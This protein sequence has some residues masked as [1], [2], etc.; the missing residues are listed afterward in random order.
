MSPLSKRDDV[1]E[2]QGRREAH[3]PD[4]TPK[5]RPG[6]PSPPPR[7]EPTGP[8]GPRARSSEVRPFLVR[9]GVCHH[10]TGG[11]EADA[12]M[13]PL[14]ILMPPHA[15]RPGYKCMGSGIKGVVL[16]RGDVI[17]GAVPASRSVPADQPGQWGTR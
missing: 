4:A 9:C 15:F 3:E 11:I 17:E 12:S 6:P 1:E 16:G 10:E 2:P 8:V 5:P 13:S 7:P 14:E